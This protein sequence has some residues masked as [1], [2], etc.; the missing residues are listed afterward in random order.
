LEKVFKTIP[1]TTKT[2]KKSTTADKRYGNADEL[3]NVRSIT[4]PGLI[5]EMNAFIR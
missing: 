4:N 2:Y 5:Y 3:D 1:K